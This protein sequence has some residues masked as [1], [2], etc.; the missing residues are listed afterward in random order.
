M[1]PRRNENAKEV[2]KMAEDKQIPEPPKLKYK[3]KPI[4]EMDLG[5]LTRA[6]LDLAEMHQNMMQKRERPRFKKQ[7]ENQPLPEVNPSFTNLQ[8]AIGAE[9]KK[10]S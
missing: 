4:V 9:I 1:C 10:R 2:V 8:D 6:S 7:M 5:E 3:E